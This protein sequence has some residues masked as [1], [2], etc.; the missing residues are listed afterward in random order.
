MLCEA[1]TKGK[2]KFSAPKA[3][4]WT[5]F[6]E[7]AKEWEKITKFTT[8]E[9]LCRLKS[10]YEKV[11]W[12]NIPFGKR[13]SNCIM[14]FLSH[15]QRYINKYGLIQESVNLAKCSNHGNS[16]DSEK[17]KNLRLTRSSNGFIKTLNRN[18]LYVKKYVKYS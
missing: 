9:K 10:V 12:L 7:K 18:V 13:H 11:L 2:E 17:V 4:G 8:F 5:E 1:V 14:I 15:T 16:A 6:R 3:E